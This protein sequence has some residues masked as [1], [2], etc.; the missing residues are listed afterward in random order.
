MPYVIAI[1][2]QKGGV[3]KTTTAL[4]LGACFVERGVRTLMVDLDPQANLSFN[5]DLEPKNNPVFHRRSADGRD[6]AGPGGK[7]IQPA[8]S[9]YHPVERLDARHRPP[10]VPDAGL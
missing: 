4:A 1:Y 2:H 8:G 7:G 10:V 5:C 9:G 6:H 3:G